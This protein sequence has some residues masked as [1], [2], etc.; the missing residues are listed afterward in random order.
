MIPRSWR[1]YSPSGSLDYGGPHTWVVIDW[2]QRRWFQVTGPAETLPDYEDGVKAVARHVDQL[3]PDVHSLVISANGDLLSVSSVDPTWEIRYPEY[4]GN[5]E[6]GEVA[7]R[8]ELVEV[9]RLNVCTDLVEYHP[10]H[11]KKE[12]VVFKYTIIQE[13]VKNIWDELHVLKALKGHESFVPFHR[14]IIDDVSEKVL[15]FTSQ[16]ISG[17]N[18]ED[19]RDQPFYFCWL[20]QLADAVDDLNLRFGLMHQDIAPR[21]VLID[22]QTQDLKLFDF[23]RSALIGSESQELQRDD[24]GG[25][26][27]TVYEAL[28]KDGH[29]R[30][31]PFDEQEVHKVEALEEWK[32]VVPLEDGKGG[33]M[34]YRSFLAEWAAVRR[35]TRTIKHFSEAT[36]PISWPAYIDPRRFTFETKNGTHYSVCRKRADALMFGDYVTCWERPPQKESQSTSCN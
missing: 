3:G 12:L 13:R 30:D 10:A 34:A 29:Y 4:S 26:I 8:S 2:D 7:R 33:I 23:D 11:S 19:Y 22:P 36:N 20:K 24:V 31:V 17:G 21:N 27:F 25:V 1:F 28:T 35:T 15:G 32:L 6:N 14:V 9:D 5:L 18:L 16:Y